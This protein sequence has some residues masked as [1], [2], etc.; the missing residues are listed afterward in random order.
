[1]T[2]ILKTEIKNNN[3]IDI[4]EE[5]II[6]KL[7]SAKDLE[8]FTVDS[9]PKDILS[10]NTLSPKG[11]VLVRYEA[12]SFTAP[13]AF[14]SVS[15]DETFEFSVFIGLRYLN[16]YNESY[17]YIQIIKTL[18]TGLSIKGKRLYP[19]KRQFVDLIKGDVYWGY[20]FNITLPTQE[21][22]CLNNVVPLWQNQ[23]I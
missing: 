17:P 12:S 14:G 6:E 20:S 19:K 7:K 22:P 15:Q 18:L 2:E 5:A 23:P 16:K 13:Q 10:Y 1:M 8:G 9:Y 11:C 4:I 3:N 21:D